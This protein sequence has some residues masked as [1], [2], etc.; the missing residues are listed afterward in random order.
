LFYTGTPKVHSGFVGA[1]K[2]DSRT[3]PKV[4]DFTQDKVAQAGEFESEAAPSTAD[5]AAH[6]T[7][8]VGDLQ[9]G[10]FESQAQAS[11]ADTAAHRTDR[12]GDIQAGEFES[13]PQPRNYD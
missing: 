5:T 1:H 8:R 12:V 3:A 9:S 11:R 13:N 6:R 2:G 10:E 4:A 7:D